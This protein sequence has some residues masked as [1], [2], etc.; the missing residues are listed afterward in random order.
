MMPGNALAR[1]SP[2]CAFK[3]HSTPDSQTLSDT[4]AR[5]NTLHWVN[6]PRDS[7]SGRREHRIDGL[8]LE[9]ATIAVV[10]V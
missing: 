1:V 9:C 3:P 8:G 2:I 10:Q 7:F 6:S 4:T 5:S